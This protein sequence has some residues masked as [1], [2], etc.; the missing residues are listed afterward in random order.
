MELVQQ[1]RGG[2]VMVEGEAGM[3]KSR[4]VEELQQRWADRVG[5]RAACTHAARRIAQAPCGVQQAAPCRSNRACHL[6]ACRPAASW[7]G[8]MT[9][10]TCSWGWAGGSARA[11]CAAAR[12]AAGRP[13][14]CSLLDCLYAT[15][16]GVH[17]PLLF[18][19]LE[20][21]HTVEV[22][23]RRC[24]HGGV[25]CARCSTTIASWARCTA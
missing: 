9:A 10:A 7:A 3:G 22:L 4:L 1:K 11:R 13:G 20:M 18:S 5:A 15:H 12:P 8:C 17:L 2:V 24:I 23:C 6:P 25:C 19:K 14:S 21:G 16:R